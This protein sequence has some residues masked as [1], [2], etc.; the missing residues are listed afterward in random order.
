MLGCWA[1]SGALVIGLVQLLGIGLVVAWAG[2]VVY[3]ARSL[4]RVPRYTYASAVA[5]GRPGDPSELDRPAAFEEWRIGAWDCRVW[6]IEGDDPGGPVVVMT[7]G[8]SRSGIAALV[9]FEAL[10]G[11]VSKMVVWDLPGHGES[12]GR[13]LLGAGEA[14]ALVEIVERVGGPVALYGWSMGAGVSI[15]A[16]VTLGADVVRGVVAEAPY[17]LP[18]TPARNVMREMGVPWRFTLRPAL[19]L[20]GLT[21]PRGPLWRGFDRRAMAAGLGVPVLVVHG[22]AD[23]ICPVEDGEAIAS[24]A[25]RGEFVRVEGGTHDGLWV[26]E[27]TRERMAEVVISFLRRIRHDDDDSVKSNS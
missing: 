15:E 14:C 23:E 25:S 19:L 16:A 2:V 4:G 27:S 1:R 13:C 6:T 20:A 5:R 26:D 24:A 10:R 7:H 9:R 22:D 18:V 17:A 11:S 12:G 8:W 3:T 21:R